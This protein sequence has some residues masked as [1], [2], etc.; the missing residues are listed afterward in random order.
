MNP[1][2]VSVEELI[3]HLRELC[4]EARQLERVTMPEIAMVT[5]TILVISPLV[6]QLLE[7]ALNKL[8][9][10]PTLVEMGDPQC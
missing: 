2:V 5:K 8:C 9:D 4:F 7:R 6:E 1:L 10:E 3:V